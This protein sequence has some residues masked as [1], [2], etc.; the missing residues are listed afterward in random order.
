[1][2]TWSW[3]MKT[4]LLVL[5]LLSMSF[6]AITILPEAATAT[7]LFVG[8]TSPGNHTTIQ[9]AI[10]AA[11]PGDTVFVYSGT[12]DEDIVIDKPLTLVG[13]ATET[14]VVT[15][16]GTGATISL[17]DDWINVTGF[18]I[19]PSSYYI[20]A[21]EVF[22]A[23]YCN[24]SGNSVVTDGKYGIWV[25][26]SGQCTFESNRISNNGTSLA[27]HHSHSITLRNNEFT[28]SGI[29]IAAA[30]VNGWTSHSIDTSNKV[31]GRPITYW[32]NLVGGIVPPGAGQI[33]LANCTGVIVENQTIGNTSVGIQLGMSSRNMIV[34]N[35]ITDSR[36]GISL[37]ESEGNLVVNNAFHGNE[38]GAFL[39]ESR[40]NT[41]SYN[42]FSHNRWGLN[43]SYGGSNSI[44]D[45]TFRNNSVG[46]QVYESW[47]NTIYRNNLMGNDKNA[48]L[49]SRFSTNDWSRN[50]WDDWLHGIPRLV[51]NDYEFGLGPD[52]EDSD[53][54]LE[55]VESP[56]N[57]P[58]IC[59]VLTP[60]WR[61]KIDGTI[62]FSGI[63]VDP[64]GHLERLEIRIGDGPWVRT[65]ASRLWTYEWDSTTV[66]NGEHTVSI[67]VFD[68]LEYSEEALIP[69]IVGNPEE[70]LFQQDWFWVAVVVVA[71]FIV[72]ALLLEQKKKKKES[73]E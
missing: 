11:S 26:Y 15:G 20:D 39:G 30:N 10:D 46:I 38:D 72:A 60:Q 66:T 31:N 42:L 58:P 56:S 69:I 1:M 35:T 51:Q 24:F 6:S 21:V 22:H 59:G 50:Y 53:P 34:D 55:P 57:I 14:T 32:K 65:N 40:K 73:D 2:A 47:F 44:T 70:V 25:Q 33:I 27:L 54:L 67:H 36:H 12:Y 8:G 13:N 43:L 9:G 3:R 41:I 71:M 48:D 23:K 52:E 28:G 29:S 17:T 7:T 45:N 68:G 64:D 16:S 62:V 5:L 61:E 18:K 63:A 37:S 19:V 49:Y 4:R